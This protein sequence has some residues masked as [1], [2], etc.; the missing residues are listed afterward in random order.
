MFYSYFSNWYNLARD[1][2]DATNGLSDVPKLAASALLIW[3]VPSVLSEL[4][5]GR[6]PDDD[7]EWWQWMA[8]TVGTYPAQTIPIARD[9]LNS[10]M[11]GRDYAMSPAAEPFKMLS[12]VARAAA[13]DAGKREVSELLVKD[14]WLALGYWFQ[15]PARQA[16]ITLSAL[17][18]AAQGEDVELRDFFFAR[19]R[20]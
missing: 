5:S 8:K 9:V 4:L 15:L 12:D 7:E 19:R 18:D 1:K 6:G 10:A 2:I 13:R 11:S 20:K 16:W 3:V 14:A 17:Y